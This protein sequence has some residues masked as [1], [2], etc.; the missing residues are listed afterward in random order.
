MKNI[1]A[2]AL[3]GLTLVSCTQKPKDIETISTNTIAPGSSEDFSQNVSNIVYFGFDR[4]DLTS[5]AKDVLAQVSS[6]LKMYTDKKANIEG[7]TDKRGTQDYNLA[8]GSRRAESVKTF[9]VENGIDS[10]R[11]STVSFGKESLL[12]DGDTAQDHALNRRAHITVLSDGDT[13]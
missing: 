10:S 2:L 7:H 3:L 9:L 1:L 5:D 4:Y 13:K 12:S 8:L 6:W 11:L